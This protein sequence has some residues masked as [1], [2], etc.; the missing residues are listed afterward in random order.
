MTRGQI[1]SIQTYLIFKSHTTKRSCLPMISIAD[2][3]NVKQKLYHGTN[4][5]ALINAINFLDLTKV[6]NLKSYQP[7]QRFANRTK[8]FESDTNRGFCI[9]TTVSIFNTVNTILIATTHF[10]S[11]VFF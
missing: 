11:A 5:V 6:L 2:T 3:E 10:C 8:I 4:K 9:N 1:N 7:K